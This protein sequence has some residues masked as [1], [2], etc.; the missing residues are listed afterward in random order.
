MV[1]II[2]EVGQ[3]HDG[4]IGILHSLIDAIS[5]TGVNSI[6][7]QTHIAAAESSKYEKFRINFSRQDASRYEYWK[8]M[9]L[10]YANWR[11][12]KVHCDEVGL[13]FL[14]S[15]FSCEAVELLERIGVSR[16]KIGSGEVS[17]LLL[18]EKVSQTGKPVILSSGMSNYDELDMSVEFL[19]Q[20][21]VPLTILQCTTSY[22]TPL[23][24]VGLNVIEELKDRY[25][26]A[27]GLSDHS[28]QIWPGIFA[29]AKGA[30]TL[31]V[32]ATFDKRM[33]GP[34][35]TS[36]LTIDELKLLCIGVRAGEVMLSSLVNKSD[37]NEF[38]DI[39][40]I[41]E[42]SLAARRTIDTGEVISFED[43]EAKKPARMGIPASRYLEVVNQKARQKILKNS[44]IDYGDL[45]SNED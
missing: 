9:E 29:V 32:H 1:N 3:A 13:E 15:P 10:S 26:V 22:P 31:E 44:F 14:S 4:S 24:K 33:F 6:K 5:E 34:D 19:R 27:V 43:L 25:H 11:E 38:K 12:I 42:K 7:F 8:R 23:E 16:Y 30:S 35:S 37:N 20:R 41:F 28:G 39:K 45:F 21:G 40:L 36:S 17:N 2:A 18:L